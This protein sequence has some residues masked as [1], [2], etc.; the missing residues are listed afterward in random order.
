MS[1]N[2]TSVVLVPARYAFMLPRI[3]S[4][5][6]GYCAVTGL[7]L[8]PSTTGSASANQGFA[9]NTSGSLY[10]A[11]NTGMCDARTA[12]I[13][14]TSGDESQRTNLTASVL[15]FENAETASCHPPMHVALVP[16]LSC[17]SIVT[18]IF[19]LTLVSGSFSSRFQT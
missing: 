14:D 9:F 5:T 2:A 8:A 1:F 11:G 15:F 12:C 4:D 13:F 19:P 6:C 10:T 3:T 16:P 7:D 17:G 18:P